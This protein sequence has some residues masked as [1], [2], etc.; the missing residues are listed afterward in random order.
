MNNN[1][2]NAYAQ[3]NIRVESSEK[4]VEMMYEGIL[5]F[6]SLAKKSIETGDIEKK[7]YWINRTSEIFIELASSLDYKT[8]GDVAV[9]LNGLY[10]QQLRFLTEA[11]IKD[12]TSKIDIVLN[13][14]K[15]LLEAWREIH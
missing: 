13:V 9:Y 8:G 6:A 3:N 7:V 5:K 11:N 14:T 4:L 2:Y 1:A 15:E 12:D 10:A